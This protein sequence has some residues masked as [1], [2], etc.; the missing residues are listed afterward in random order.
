[1]GKTLQFKTKTIEEG[2]ANVAKYAIKFSLENDLRFVFASK[3]YKKDTER[4]NQ[5][6]G[7]YKKHLNQKE[8]KSFKNRQ[9]P[10]FHLLK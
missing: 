1:M 2:F 3:R 10:V 4:F 7:F 9:N 8:F 5:E 6:I